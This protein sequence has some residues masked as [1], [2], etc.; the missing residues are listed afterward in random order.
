M[1]YLLTPNSAQTKQKTYLLVKKGKPFYLVFRLATSNVAIYKRVNITSSITVQPC[2][3][4][5][6]R[7]LK[8][9]LICIQKV[10]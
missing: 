1:H 10:S 7:S 6:V 4:I 5:F 8:K 2:E 9:M 3:Q